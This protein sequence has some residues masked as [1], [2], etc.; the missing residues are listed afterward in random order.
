MSQL[1]QTSFTA[2]FDAVRA[3]EHPGS[4]PYDRW[5]IKRERS[6]GTTHGINQPIARGPR[7]YTPWDLAM[8]HRFAIAL[9]RLINTPWIMRR[10]FNFLRKWHPISVVNGY[11]L[12]TTFQDVRAVLDDANHFEVNYPRAGKHQIVAMRDT[13]EYHD[14]KRMLM[15]GIGNDYQLQ[16]RTIVEDCAIKILP[17]TPGRFDL[18][19]E[20]ARVIAID[21]THSY[22]G[23]PANPEDM[24]RWTRTILR[25]VFMNLMNDQKTFMDAEQSRGQLAI[26]IHKLIKRRN[27]AHLAGETYPDNFMGRLL[28][29]ARANDSAAGN[30]SAR[31][32]HQ[33]DAVIRD[34]M[35][36]LVTALA[37]NISNSIARSMK[38][39]LDHPAQLKGAVDAAKAGD[40]DLLFHYILEALRFNPENPFLVR[41]CS[42]A[43]TLGERTSRVTTIPVDTVVMAATEGA[44]FDGAAFPDPGL[45][46][47]TR[48][49]DS[50]LHFGWGMHQ[51]FGRG[52]AQ[53]VLPAAVGA[54][55]RLP[56]LRRVGGFAGLATYHG[57]FP[58]R[59]L[60]EF[61]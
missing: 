51:C 43:A 56:N 61:G 22:L 15:S 25:D 2:S 1:E 41:R 57:A 18:V 44:M 38:Y 19:S 39:L 59:M 46:Q 58:K 4:S 28:I 21:L 37:D 5:A 9:E 12:V 48:P 3:L 29:S 23:I 35:A 17:T 36:G 30:D 32:S 27:R 50:Y 8:K 24:K 34:L 14:L 31:S 55:L 47:T 7:T 40:N 42:K 33:S 52:I 20:Y 6:A 54:L 45:F 49:I 26:H 16:L 60:V 10:F 53:A 11:A 13:P